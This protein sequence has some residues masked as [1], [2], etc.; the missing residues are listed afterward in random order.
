MLSDVRFSPPATCAR[1]RPVILGA[2]PSTLP[3]ICRPL[4]SIPRGMAMA[5]STVRPLIILIASSVMAW[6]AGM[7]IHGF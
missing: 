1:R 7:A 4:V 2:S 6:A 5:K 3:A